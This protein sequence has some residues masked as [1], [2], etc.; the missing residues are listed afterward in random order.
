MASL[1]GLFTIAALLIF[2]AGAAHADC[3][4]LAQDYRATKQGLEPPQRV[5]ALARAARE[6]CLALVTELIG[7][8][9][10]VAARGRLGDTAL[11]H[12]VRA[13]DPEVAAYLLARGADIEQRKLNGETPLTIA[14]QFYRPLT[15][16]LL[17]ERGADP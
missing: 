9:A 4:E 15:A 13:A 5:A 14:I 1:C 16:T 7:D 8:G 6:G 17:L 2:A 11:H 10:S 3:A 12:A